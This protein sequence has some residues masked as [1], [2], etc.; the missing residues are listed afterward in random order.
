MYTKN[1]KEQFE[2]IM[3]HFGSMLEQN[4]TI[5]VLWSQRNGCIFLGGVNNEKT[6]VDLDTRIA[7]KTAELYELLMDEIV[8]EALYELKIFDKGLYELNDEEKASVEKAIVDYTAPFPE[9]ANIIEN[10]FM[11]PDGLCDVF[12]S[13]LI[14]AKSIDIKDYYIDLIGLNNYAREKGMLA[15]Y[16]PWQDKERFIF[17]RGADHSS[18]ND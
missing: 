2:K 16:L 7:L 5:E 18:E 10:T 12:F 15:R 6:S 13:D 11:V 4:D 8:A 3:K 9:Y 1:E 14:E 17:K